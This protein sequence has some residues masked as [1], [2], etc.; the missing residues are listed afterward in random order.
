MAFDLYGEIR[1]LSTS[2]KDAG[3]VSWGQ[4]LDKA[5][6]S[7]TMPGEVFGALRQ[8]LLALS[9]TPIPERLQ[10]KSSIDQSIAFINSY[11]GPMR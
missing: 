11:L 2:L 4:R 8:E 3:E 6:A 7:G 9:R 10:L 1:K 5:M